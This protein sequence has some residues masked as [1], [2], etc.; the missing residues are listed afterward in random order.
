MAINVLWQ[1]RNFVANSRP[2]LVEIS[3][4]HYMMEGP[5]QAFQIIDTLYPLL[6]M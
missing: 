4:N 5:S 3:H 1:L 6:W 2:F